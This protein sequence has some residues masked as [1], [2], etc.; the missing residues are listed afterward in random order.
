MDNN[1]FP[2]TDYDADEVINEFKEK[3]K[4]PKSEEVT[5]VVKPKNVP[6]KLLLSFIAT[7]V[8]GAVA[9]YMMLPALNIHD[10]QMYIFIILL[11]A[12]FMGVFSLLCK[13]NV[14]IE[15]REYVKKKSV[16][17]AVIV[18]VILVVMAIGWVTGITLFRAS[19][20]SQL[21]T[22]SD[23]DFEADFEEIRD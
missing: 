8:I 16:I 6:L 9:Y 21:I 5:A 4:W 22:I 7:V 13:A 11:I 15:H 18:G 17:P 10:T 3:I 1:N 19:S 20:Y 12:V 14:K 23:G 2:N